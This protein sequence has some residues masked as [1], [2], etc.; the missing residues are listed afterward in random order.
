MLGIK[1][2]G[3]TLFHYF[4]AFSAVCLIFAI[5]LISC[6]AAQA[7]DLDSAEEELKHGK[8]EVAILT[9]TRLLQVN[10]NDGAAQKGLLKAYLE[11]GQYAEAERRAKGFLGFKEHEAQ[12]RLVLGEVYAVTGRYKEALTEFEK[13]RETDEIAVKMQAELRRSEI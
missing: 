1:S 2:K 10:Q 4:P 8:Y 7:Q 13:V 11:T 12:T 5:H 9:F 6:A 3:I